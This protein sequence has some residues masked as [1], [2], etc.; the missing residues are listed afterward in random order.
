M[1]PSISGFFTV[2]KK[3]RSCVL[4]SAGSGVKRVLVVL[5]GLRWSCFFVSM[6]LFLASMVVALLVQ[7]VCLCLLMS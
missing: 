2:S 4:C 6:K 5:S 7:S 1:R 3:R